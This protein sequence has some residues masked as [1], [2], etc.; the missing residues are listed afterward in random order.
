MRVGSLSA[1]IPDRWRDANDLSRK[2]EFDG[3]PTTVIVLEDKVQPGDSQF[4][5]TQVAVTLL[6]PLEI[7]RDNC[8]RIAEAVSP[9][10]P[11]K[12]SISDPNAAN[13]DGAPGCT[14]RLYANGFGH[15]SLT[16]L[17]RK[18]TTFTVRCS[19]SERTELDRACERAVYGLR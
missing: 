7:N 2:I 10:L 13:F 8:D 19:G 18:G 16:V 11:E 15:S 4:A 5:L 6:E 17:T 1:E 9:R 3:S 12:W 14:L